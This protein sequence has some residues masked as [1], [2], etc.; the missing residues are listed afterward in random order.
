MG[1]PAVHIQHGQRAGPR[2]VCQKESAQWLIHGSTAGYLCGQESV[3]F[4]CRHTSSYLTVGSENNDLL[5]F[6][7]TNH[8]NEVPSLLRVLSSPLLS[9]P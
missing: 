9:P 1:P 6:E 4:Y 2:S 8:K 3:Q 5:K 7:L